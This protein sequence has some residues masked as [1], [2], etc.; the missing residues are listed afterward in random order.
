MNTESHK[1][2]DD[3]AR[4]ACSM[5]PY[6]DGE[7][8]PG[9]AVDMEA[10]V[11]SCAACAERVALLRAMR[12]SLKRTCNGR[13]PDALRARVAAAMAAERRREA[14]VREAQDTMRPKLVKLR[15]AV[16]LAAAAGVV[17][18]MSM[19]HHREQGRDALPW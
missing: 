3:C 10:H 4:F 9:H 2:M 11:I 15:Y 7:L 1:A 14:E 12:G 6:V 13:A 5:A 17:F 18:A 16:G 19:K 8:D